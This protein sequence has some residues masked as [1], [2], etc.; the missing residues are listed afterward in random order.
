[1]DDR[2]D[3]PERSRKRRRISSSTPKD[4]NASHVYANDT[5][6]FSSTLRPQ[7]LPY[8]AASTPHIS[9]TRGSESS[10][11]TPGPPAPSPLVNTPDI[12]SDTLMPMADTPRSH[13]SSQIDSEDDRSSPV[14]PG[15]PLIEQ[16]V[17][18]EVRYRQKLILRGHKRGV[19]CV[20]FSPDGKWIASCCTSSVSAA[21]LL[22][23]ASHSQYILESLQC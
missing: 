18:T 7:P 16:E 6:P 15:S 14:P 3:S 19:A 13:R 5:L 9:V 12:D 1:M 21:Q 20:K 2:E 10:V 8:S 11:S 17:K 22:V 23:R 4:D